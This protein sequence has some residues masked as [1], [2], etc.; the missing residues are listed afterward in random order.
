MSR[1]D[2]DLRQR[3]ADARIAR[4]AT[5]RP[6]GH[7]HIV[8]ITYAVPI[9]FVLEGEDGDRIVTAVDQKPKSTTSLQRLR[10][11]RAHPSVSVLV[12]EYDDD[13]SRLW[14][15]RADGTA[16]ILDDGPGRDRAIELL[17]EK[18]AQYREARP[19]GPV[20]V[21]TV[22]RWSSWSA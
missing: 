22:E 1:L 16:A 17:T 15:A 5:V 2:P 20:I 14:W 7:P 4:L 21:V 10:N 19:G 8:P 11:I 6:D 13:W 12:D 18:Y 3:V 9:S